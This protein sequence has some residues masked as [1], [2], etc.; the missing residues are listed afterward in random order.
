MTLNVGSNLFKDGGIFENSPED[1]DNALYEA[2]EVIPNSNLPEEFNLDNYEILS[3]FD[4]S[5]QDSIPRGLFFQDDGT[6]MFVVGGTNVKVYQYNLG[7]AWDVTSAVHSAPDDLDVSTED[8][9]PTDIAFKTDGSKLYVIGQQN[10]K[11][12]Q[13]DLG[14]A[15]DLS[16]AS[17]ASKFDDISGEE[18]NPTGLFFEPDGEVMYITGD[19]SDFIQKYTLSTAWDVSTSSSAG[20]KRYFGSEDGS[21]QGI[22]FKENGTKLYFVGVGG[23]NAYQYRLTEAWNIEKAIFEKQKYVGIETLGPLGIF[24]KPDGKKMFIIGFNPDDKVYEYI[25]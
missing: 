4:V 12:Y 18:S 6:K 1:N 3:S 25:I 8:N 16:T 24:F 15:W 5:G 10:N 17:Y 22:F 14:T 11:V 13:Y 7:T 23:V 19:N 20:I 21:P 2:G 9:T